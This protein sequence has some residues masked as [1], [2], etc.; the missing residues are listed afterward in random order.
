[1]RRQKAEGR[2][3]KKKEAGGGRHEAEGGIR[4]G[5]ETVVEK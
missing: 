5:E 1:M 3:R 2:S 4:K